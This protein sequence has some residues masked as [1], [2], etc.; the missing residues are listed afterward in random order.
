M[1]S[2]L[3]VFGRRAGTFFVYLGSREKTAV[4]VPTKKARALGRGLG[5][6]AR[7]DGRL[8]I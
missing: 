7:K 3:F 6:G 1:M 2:R 5:F 4:G 8:S